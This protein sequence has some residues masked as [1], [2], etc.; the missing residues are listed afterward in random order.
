MS[1]KARRFTCIACASLMALGMVGCGSPSATTS[2]DDNPE[3]NSEMSQLY[4]SNFNGG[5]GTEWLYAARARF[6]EA[7]KDYSFEEGK[8]GVQVI[9]DTNKGLPADIAATRSEIYFAENVNLYDYIYQGKVLEIT[10]IVTESL[11]MNGETESIEDKLSDEY[12]NF[13]K[14]PNGKYYALPHYRST[15]ALTYDR[16]LFDE[17]D[18]F[19]GADGEVN[20][21]S[22]STSLSKGPDGKS[23]TYDDGLP[24]TYAEFY[25]LCYNMTRRGVSPMHWSGMYNFYTTLFLA[26]LKADFEGAENKMFYTF[27]GTATKLVDTINSDGTITYKAPTTI[28]KADGYKAYESAGTYYALDFFYNIIKN[29][30]YYTGAMNEATTHLDAQADFLLSNYAETMAPI[31]MLVEGS[32]WPHESSST[33]QQMESRYSNASLEER[34]LALMPYPKA[35]TAQVGEAQTIVDTSKSA[36]F[37]NATIKE[38]KIE[39][40]KTFMKFLHTEESLVEFLLQTNMTRGFDFEVP[41]D[42]YNKLNTFAKSV[43]DVLKNGNVVLPMDNSTLYYKNYSTFDLE[44]IFATSYGTHPLVALKKGY[45]S[46]QIFEKARYKFNQATWG[47]LLSE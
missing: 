6:E 34:H 40:A 8:K 45:T 4:V 38:E 22:T 39:L 2:S 1:K 26:A 41:T 12:K 42:V 33:F 29:E 24:A 30:Y 15:Y 19:I 32:W 31:A 21:K 44:Q 16:D 35:T 28:T 3:V 27:E 14:T 20:Q 13:F 47:P 11:D 10:D 23:G 36:A 18:L 17:K 25:N 5:V 37:I 46:S 43:V 9:V 7:Y